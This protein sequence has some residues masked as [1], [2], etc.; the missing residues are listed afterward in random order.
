M[1]KRIK[2]PAQGGRD[3]N[4]GVCDLRVPSYGDYLF[5]KYLFTYLTAL[6]LSCGMRT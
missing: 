1:Y 5:K 2:W 6:A 4:P 3:L